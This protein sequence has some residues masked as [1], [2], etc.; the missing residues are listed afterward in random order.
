[1][2][3]P[4]RLRRGF[5]LIELLVVIAIIGVL[6]ALLLPAVQSAREAARRAQCTNNLKQVGIA[7]QSYHDQQGSFPIGVQYYGSWDTSCAFQA[8]GHSLFTLILNQMEGNTVYNAI[9]FNF[10]AGG[11]AQYGVTPGRVNS[12]ALLTR[13]NSYICPSEASE[14]I[15]YQIPAQSN[16]PYSWSSYAGMAGTYDIIRW[17]YGCPNE[18]E[19]TGMFGKNF[20]Y[21]IS[22]NTDGTSN[23][24]YVGETSRFKGDKDNVFNTWTRALWFGSAVA[25][26]SRVQGFA[27]SLPKI[28]ANLAI[29]DIPSNNPFTDY[30]NPIYRNNGQFGFRSQHPG[31]ANFLFGDGSVHFLK[32]TISPITYQALSTRNLG[33][34]ISASSY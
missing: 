5:T 11:G 3:S 1:M 22:D 14:Q 24:I 27:L 31:G 10:A 12:T 23:T 30:Q 21:K 18:I 13:V 7:L 20:S 8:S 34:A 15:P 28:N 4:V 19:P 17:W 2:R 29:P 9:N 6:I 16:N 25:G 33:E 32:E 26:T